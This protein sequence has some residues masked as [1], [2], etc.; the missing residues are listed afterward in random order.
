MP[1]AALILD[2]GDGRGNT[3]P[4]PDDPGWSNVAQRGFWSAVYLG[5][6]WMLTARHVGGGDVVLNGEPVPWV[7]GS[8]VV[9]RNEDRTLADL[10]MFRLQREPDLPELTVVEASPR[11][12]AEIVMIGKGRSRGRMFRWLGHVGYRWDSDGE[13]RWGTNTVASHMLDGQIRN[14]ATFSARFSVAGSPYEAIATRGDSGGAVFVRDDGHWELAGIMLAVDSFPGQPPESGAYGNVTY[15]ADLAHYREQIAR[16]LRGEKR[17]VPL[18]DGDAGA[19]SAL[20][21]PSRRPVEC[22][23]ERGN[24]KCDPQAPRSPY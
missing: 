15:I 21:V 19:Q 24:R 1:A 11:V 18:Y 6:G 17:P 5:R 2:I 13:M 14:S 16:M 10:A 12:G 3:G 9:L 7:E 20:D 8:E 4:P 22:A 23:P